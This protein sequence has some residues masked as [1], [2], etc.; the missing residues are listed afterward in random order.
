MVAIGPCV[1][2]ISPHVVA[3]SLCVV[4]IGLCVVAIGPCVVATNQP[5][6]PQVFPTWPQ[7]GLIGMEVSAWHHVFLFLFFSLTVEAEESFEKNQSKS[8]HTAL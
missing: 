4:A 3:I 1:V 2:A 8:I 5:T 6:H 7:D